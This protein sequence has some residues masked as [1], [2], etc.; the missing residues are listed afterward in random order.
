MLNK[1]ILSFSLCAGL[2]TTM[3]LSGGSL[4]AFA[5]EDDWEIIDESELIEP[6]EM[7]N[8]SEITT[9]DKWD[10]F[11][12]GFKNNGKLPFIS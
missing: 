12:L 3:L 11:R 7:I 1:K 9:D 2:T 5:A 6:W 4:T 8:K 10:I